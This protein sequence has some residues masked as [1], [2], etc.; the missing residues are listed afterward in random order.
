MNWLSA[1]YRLLVVIS[2]DIAANGRRLGE[3][4]G[5]LLFARE[6]RFQIYTKAS[7]SCTATFAKP[8]VTCWFISSNFT[9]KFTTN[10]RLKGKQLLKQELISCR[11]L[12]SIKIP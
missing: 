10:V 7:A 3:G 2:S 1:R 8:L 6:T 9:H 5:S 11:I 12:F 4:G